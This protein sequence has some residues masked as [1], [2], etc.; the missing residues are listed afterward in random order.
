MLGSKC[1][2]HIAWRR[3]KFRNGRTPPTKEVL[4]PRANLTVSSSHC[5]RTLTC[6][7]PDGDA[8]DLSQVLH[9]VPPVSFASWRG[10][11]RG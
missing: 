3:G 1:S 2:Q 7:I 4:S 10:V 6:G 5:R 11:R 8:R 9:G